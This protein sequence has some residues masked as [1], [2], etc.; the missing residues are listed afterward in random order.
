M[1]SVLLIEDSRTD[2]M[3]IKSCLKLS[4]MACSF[5]IVER[6]VD[7]EV[8]LKHPFD[9]AIVDLNLPD[10]C[11]MDTVRRV[12]ELRPDLPIVV[13]S[14][15]A[16]DEKGVQAMR[17]GAQDFI[18]KQDFN[19]S[20]LERSVRFA[21]ERHQRQVLS[22]RLRERDTEYNTAR[23]VQQR[24]MPNEF[25][26]VPGYELAG[27][28]RSAEAV[29]GDFFDF[30]PWPDGRLGVVIGDVSGHGFPAALLMAS[31]R[32]V[33]RALKDF[34]PEPRELIALANRHICDDT[35][36]EQFV[37]VFLAVVDLESRQVGY[38]GAGHGAVLIRNSGE[39]I[40]LGGTGLPAGMTKDLMMDETGSFQMEPGDL[41]AIYTDGLYECRNPDNEMLGQD[42]VISLLKNNRTAALD[43]LIN[44]LIE[45]SCNFCEPATPRDDITIAL[46][47][48]VDQ[49]DA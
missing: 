33:V 20:T 44:S 31:T 22:Q 14:G 42:T 34:V 6:L 18:L 35:R 45:V 13:F 21:I 27:R 19:R 23:S 32:R 17:E 47:R 29:G 41:L 2:A 12:R 46:V 15:D 9:V 43:E 3:L 49:D 28:C 38:V 36:Y 26:S 48:C 8:E 16:D 24:L 5:V 37:E 1:T 39:A 25:P 11:G 7:A 4:Q 30:V 40:E 10:S